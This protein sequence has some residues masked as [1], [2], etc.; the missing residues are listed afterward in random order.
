MT[1]TAVP[2]NAPLAWL[3]RKNGYRTA[4]GDGSAFSGTERGAQAAEVRLERGWGEQFRVQT[5]RG[6]G[7]EGAVLIADGEQRALTSASGVA[8]LSGNVPPERIEVVNRDWKI[9]WASGLDAAT[10]R[11]EDSVERQIIVYLLP[12]E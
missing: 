9:V 7:L 8:Y 5:P 3:V 10:G 11:L 12:P 4:I 1:F 2:L 6:R